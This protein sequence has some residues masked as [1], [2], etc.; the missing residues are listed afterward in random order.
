GTLARMGGV[1]ARTTRGS[2]AS[3]GMALL[4]VVMGGLTAKF[5]GAAVA[6]QDFPLCGRN[7]DV[8]PASVHVQLTHR[9]LAFLVVLHL[10]GLLVGVYRR[11]EALVAR[12]A[13]TIAAAL[14][15]VQLGVAAAMVL[16]HLPPV[17]RSLHEATG[18]SIW[19][20]TF[21]LAYLSRIASGG[22]AAVFLTEAPRAAGSVPRPRMTHGAASSA[23]R[24]AEG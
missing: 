12:R 21:A 16:G 23:P 3:A 24:G 18:V 6:C 15:L 17:L 5:P 13:V 8:L 1:S 20:S 4:T 10:M 2:F 22:S 19:I 7:A 11:N 14:G 9:V